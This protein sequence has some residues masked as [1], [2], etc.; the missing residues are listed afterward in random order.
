MLALSRG[1]I[2]ALERLMGNWLGSGDHIADVRY[3]SKATGIR[4]REFRLLSEVKRTKSG[5][6]RTSALVWPFWGVDRS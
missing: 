3:G 5:A 2:V 6:K 4:C 1:L